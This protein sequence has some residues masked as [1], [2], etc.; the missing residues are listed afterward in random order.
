MK[1]K[2]M[3]GTLLVVVGAAFPAAQSQTAD[4][5][6]PSQPAATSDAKMRNYY[7]LKVGS[8]WHYTLDPG[9][10]QK[11]T[12]TSAIAAVE[13]SNGKSLS[14]LEFTVNGQ[15]TPNTEHL[16]SDENG[17]YRTKSNRLDLNPPL[18]I[19]KYPIKANQS[20]QS[21]PVIGGQLQAMTCREGAEEEIQVPAGKYRA[22]PCTIEMT[23]A[24]AKLMITNWFAED[25]GVVKQRIEFGPRV[26]SMELT[27]YE[28]A[29]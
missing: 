24:G 25:V 18:C 15:I 11:S 29:K 13:T 5:A 2:T 14:R 8:K 16:M 4:K 12:V 19:L 10:G 21:K 23:Q 1:T 22:I 26:F 6:K 17:V 3:F 28:P 27:K 7:P 20:W 9:N